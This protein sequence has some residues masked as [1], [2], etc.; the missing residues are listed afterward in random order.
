[1][2]TLIEIVSG[3]ELG[4]VLSAWGIFAA[5]VMAIVEALTQS[6]KAKPY[7]MRLSLILGPLLGVLTYWLGW[8]DVPLHAEYSPA[9]G[10][11]LE[12]EIRH[13]VGAALLG[14]AS[15]L[16]LAKPVHDL[17]VVGFIK[18]L[19]LGRGRGVGPTTPRESPPQ[20]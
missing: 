4:K 14:L 11:P 6:E 13:H 1:M 8:I 20:A 10:D 2:D 17:G 19:L 5:A 18:S 15:T 7:R 3:G 16:L 12:D 9:A